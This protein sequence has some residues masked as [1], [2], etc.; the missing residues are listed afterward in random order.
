LQQVCSSAVFDDLASTAGRS[1]KRATKEIL[2]KLH[3]TIKLIQILDF[4]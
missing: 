2:K 4:Q 1:F 3:I